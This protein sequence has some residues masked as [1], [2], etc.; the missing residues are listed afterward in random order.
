MKP[1]DAPTATYET[2]ASFDLS[3]A[4]SG[5][6]GSQAED[7]LPC[8]EEAMSL[9]LGIHFQANCRSQ[10]QGWMIDMRLKVQCGC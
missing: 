7:D 10:L 5:A 3:Q 9:I 6:P 4:S 8:A 2:N 1:Q